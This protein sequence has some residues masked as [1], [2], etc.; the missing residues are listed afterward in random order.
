MS[1]PDLVLASTSVYRKTL[2]EKIQIPFHC[3]APQI[4]ETPIDNETAEQL[5]QRLALEKAKAVAVQH[6]NSWVIG[7]DQVCTINGQIVG[8]PG[9]ESAAIHQLQAAAGQRITFFTGLCLYDAVQQ[10]Y[11]LCAESFHVHF[12]Q[13]NTEQIRRYINAEQPLNCAGSFKSEGLGIT[14]FHKLEGKDPNCLI[15]L[16]LIALVDMLAAWGIELPL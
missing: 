2:L 1:I 16:P 14:L 9:T 8:K 13:L 15:G 6:P 12:R 3:V 7:S 4:N 11:Q 10:R 5:V